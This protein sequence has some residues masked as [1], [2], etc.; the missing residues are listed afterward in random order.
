MRTEQRHAETAWKVLRHL[1]QADGSDDDSI[2]TIASIIRFAVDEAVT[3]ERAECIRIA[4]EEGQ[5]ALRP[6]YAHSP[7][8]AAQAI[9]AAIRQRCGEPST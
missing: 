8:E 2:E 3:A 5:K 4:E 9:A 7:R 6:G 1:R